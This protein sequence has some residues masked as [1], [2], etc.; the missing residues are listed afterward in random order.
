MT[1]TVN[2]V[3]A[4]QSLAFADT[5]SWNSAWASDVVYDVQLQAGLNSVQLA[6][7][8][9]SGPNFDSVKVASLGAGGAGTGGGG[10]EG[11]GL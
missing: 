7:N 6:T 1:L 5:G 11:G 10:G 3:V 4:Q 2:G 9:D 8:G